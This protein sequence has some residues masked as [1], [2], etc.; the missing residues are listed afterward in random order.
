MKNKKFLIVGFGIGIFSIVFLFFKLNSVLA[1]VVVTFGL[2]NNVSWWQTCAGDVRVDTDFTDPL[3]GSSISPATCGTSTYKNSVVS[4]YDVSC[5]IHT[6]SVVYTG[7]TDPSGTSNPFGNGTASDNNW[8]VGGS[9]ENQET[10]NPTLLK[11]ASYAVTVDRLKQGGVNVDDPQYSLALQCAGN[12]L[13]NCN[14][15]SNLNPDS[16]TDILYKASGSLTLTGAD[17]YEFPANSNFVILVNGDLNINERI[18]IPY[19]STVT[20]IVSGDINIGANVGSNHDN[21]VASTLGSDGQQHADIEGM[22]STDQNFN[23][24]SNHPSGCSSGTADSRLNIGGNI[25][26]GEGDT[27]GQV[28]NNRSLCTGTG[29]N[30]GD[31]NCPS[32]FIDPRP[33]FIINASN[34]IRSNDLIWQEVSPSYSN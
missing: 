8:A 32:M 28:N 23:I 3:P 33:D 13:T 7:N 21:T 6:W 9:D 5:P 18:W 15:S 25:V 2:T 12:D 1:Q 20:F 22:F 27:G 14:L 4:L 10:F 26:A 19:G 24:L 34:I 11:K 17:P 16:K 30:D 31:L 29:N